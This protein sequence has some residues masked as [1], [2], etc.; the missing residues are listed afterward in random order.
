MHQVNGHL[1]H[2]RIIQLNQTFGT[3]LC[4]DEDKVTKTAAKYYKLYN[5]AD[6][7][8]VITWKYRSIRDIECIA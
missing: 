7:T 5:K 6:S 4:F 2:G 1:V 3:W 8:N